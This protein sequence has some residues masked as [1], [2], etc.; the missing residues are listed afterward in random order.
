MNDF[1][2]SGLLTGITSTA[3][4]FFIYYKNHKSRI[5][6]EC[7]VFAF[8]VAAWGYG[9]CKMAL[10]IISVLATFNISNE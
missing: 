2:L 10:V 8:L 7:Y 3:M 1:G 4:A 9:G 6:K 5:N